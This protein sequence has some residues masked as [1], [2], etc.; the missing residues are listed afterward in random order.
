MEGYDSCRTR[1]Q[2]GND[3]PLR[4]NLGKLGIIECL[5]FLCW[6]MAREAQCRPEE[7]WSRDLSS[8]SSMPWRETEQQELNPVPVFFSRS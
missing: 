2:V 5:K 8:D 7:E 6:H 4:T 1:H 3:R